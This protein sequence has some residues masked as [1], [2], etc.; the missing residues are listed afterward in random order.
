MRTTP[1]RPH[2]E[3]SYVV[4]AVERRRHRRN[5]RVIATGIVGALGLV[6]AGVWAV[7]I[8]TTSPGDGS[9][10]AADL[11]VGAPPTGDV[12]VLGEFIDPG[13][14][15]QLTIDFEGRWG[16]IPGD[17]ATADAGDPDV[18]GNWELF[19]INVSTATATREFYAEIGVINSPTNFSALQVAFALDDQL[20]A[21][22]DLDAPVRSA[23]LYVESAD[24]TIVFSDLVGGVAGVGG[25][26]CIGVA[27]TGGAAAND[28]T[29]TFLR[30]ANPTLVPTRPAFFAILGEHTP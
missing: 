27:D 20:C 16:N 28:P 5:R 21:T 2:E 9:Q 7:T 12:S 29:G 14:D 13:P 1:E 30:R 17:T 3:Q 11:F 23:T 22:A 25:Q 18:G 6:L 8:V 26:Y 15:S 4:D 19:E 24:S 10:S